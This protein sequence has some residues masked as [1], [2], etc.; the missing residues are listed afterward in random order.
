MH[1]GEIKEAER[2]GVF[3]SRLLRRQ[4]RRVRKATVWC[5]SCTVCCLST[6]RGFASGCGIARARQAIYVAIKVF[7]VAVL[8]QADRE[9]RLQNAIHY[10]R[11]LG[12]LC[13]MVAPIY[14]I[15]TFLSSCFISLTPQ[16]GSASVRGRRPA[17]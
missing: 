8:R 3:R 1:H 9:E 5:C 11:A 14:L 15:L 12:R 7:S 10:H 6:N 17:T 4:R 2:G 16:T 13:C